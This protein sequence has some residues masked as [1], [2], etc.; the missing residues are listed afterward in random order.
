MSVLSEAISGESGRD[1][2]GC[3]G[4]GDPDRTVL[5]ARKLCH[6]KPMLPQ[7]AGGHDFVSTLVFL[8]LNE[9]S[10]SIVSFKIELWNSAF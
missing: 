1:L 2:P 7:R 4:I 8:F 3:S 6:R 5:R 9:L 10:V